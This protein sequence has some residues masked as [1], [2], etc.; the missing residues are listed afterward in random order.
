MWCAFIVVEFRGSPEGAERLQLPKLRVVN[1]LQFELYHYLSTFKC[2]LLVQCLRLRLISLKHS[3]TL[4]Y[5][6]YLTLQFGPVGE[7]FS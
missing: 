4:K 7:N 2:R 5:E 6:G 3:R 1:N